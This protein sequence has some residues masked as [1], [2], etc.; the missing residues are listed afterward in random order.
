MALS[1][2]DQIKKVLED[3]KYILL[4]F[5][6]QSN[7]D[8]L[9]A[10]AALKLFFE[11]SH[12]QADV[13]VDNFT[14]PKNLKFLPGSGAVKKELSNLQKFIIKVDISKAPIETL[15]YDVKDNWLSIYLTPKQGVISKNEL[16]T[17]QTT[18]KYDLI[19]TLNTPDLESLGTIFYNNTDLF[20]RVP[21]LNIDYQAS[22]E[23]YG[24]INLIDLAST[25]V[26]EVAYKIL[27]QIPTTPIDGELS[28]ALLTGMI[29]AT[30]S[31]KNPNIT[32]HTLHL[33]S[34]LITSGAE[35]EKIVHQLY[36]TR[37]IAT[38]KLWGQALTHLEHQAR[39]GLIST[40]VTREDFSR[41]GAGVEDINGIIE[42]LIGN[43]P[44]A[45]I[46]LLLHEFPENMDKNKIGGIIATDKNF[47]ALHLVKPLDPHG[48]KRQA[49][50]ILENKTLK[51]AEEMMMKMI[52]EM[53]SAK[54][55]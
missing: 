42:E 53:I 18:F 44:E 24:Q 31:F 45:K 39:L 55:V 27:K 22:N 29:V 52:E 10:A 23:R 49:T 32:P 21:I 54:N 30:K 2:I 40:T 9:A 34:Q 14:L 16:R 20:Y 17:A 50:F 37:S 51:E 48:T 35:R 6:T 19:I 36:R 7:G 46:I 11:R 4:V 41:T 33:A 12:K 26:S 15:S 25:S 38:L 28:T 13:V 5:P 3:S 43:S 1:E 8:A 47:D